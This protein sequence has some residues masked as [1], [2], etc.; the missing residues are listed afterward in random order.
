MARLS[1]ALASTGYTAWALLQGLRGITRRRPRGIVRVLLEAFQQPLDSRFECGDACFEGADI[2]LDGK[3]RLLPQLR[4][5]GW[6]RVHGPRSYAAGHWLASLTY[7]G[8]LNAYYSFCISTLDSK[9][10]QPAGDFHGQIVIHFLS[11]AKH[12]LNNAI[13]YQTLVLSS[14]AICR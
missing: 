11:I 3:G 4:W 5:K 6:G 13:H 10:V 9:V 12:I 8:H 1:P 7:C 2:F 14:L